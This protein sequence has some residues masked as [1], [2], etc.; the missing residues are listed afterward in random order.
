MKTRYLLG[1]LI[2]IAG[3]NWL[4]GAAGIVAA[5]F[6]NLSAPDSYVAVRS[7]A[8]VVL[9]IGVGIVAGLAVCY[10]SSYCRKLGWLNGALFVS[11]TILGCL[12]AGFVFYSMPWNWTLFHSDLFW[13]LLGGLI[14][15]GLTVGWIGSCI[16]RKSWA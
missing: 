15:S 9:S 3:I 6:V 16:E 14:A 12:A 13:L 7:L 2:V 11:A 4:I 8:L 5:I 10:V 1:A